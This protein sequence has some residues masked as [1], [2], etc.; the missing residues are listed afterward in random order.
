MTRSPTVAVRP[1]RGHHTDRRVTNPQ[2]L[3]TTWPT[4]GHYS[5]TTRSPARP[6]GRPTATT[7]HQPPYDHHANTTRQPA[8]CCTATT[9]SP[10]T[11]CM[12]VTW[13]PHSLT[14]T[15]GWPLH[16]HP[17]TNNRLSPDHSWL[18]LDTQV[19]GI[20]QIH[21]CITIQTILYLYHIIKYQI[22]L[23]IIDIV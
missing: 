1:L 4:P 10:P 7:Q 2:H 18:P 12:A 23:S 16:G 14:I 9:Q 8:N 17:A 13:S 22:Y 15:V 6:I 20:H 19:H 21:M 11:G 3:A 5:A